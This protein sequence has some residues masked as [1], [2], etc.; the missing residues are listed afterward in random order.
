MPTHKS[1]TAVSLAFTLAVSGCGTVRDTAVTGI[2][3]AGGAAIGSEI[4]G[5]RP[6]GAAIGAGAGLLTGLGLGWL[7]RKDRE[8]HY[9]SGYEKGQ[10]DSVKQL[11]WAGKEQHKRSEGEEYSQN[12]Y[13]IQTPEF[14]DGGVL[15]EPSRRVI[16]ITE[17]NQ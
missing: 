12:Y 6:E 8:N 10:S 3:T 2:T 9:R 11:Y 17:P 15:H 16:G 14:V 13:V 1:F 4:S 7:G 5:G